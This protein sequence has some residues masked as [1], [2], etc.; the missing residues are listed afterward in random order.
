[1]PKPLIWTH[2]TIAI[3]SNGGA[4]APPTGFQGSDQMAHGKRVLNAFPPFH[5]S[6][7]ID[8]PNVQN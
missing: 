3:G 4:L 2:D 1:M 5:V 8:Y 6:Y 7:P